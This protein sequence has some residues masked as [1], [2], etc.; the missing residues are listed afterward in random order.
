KKRYIENKDF[1]PLLKIDANSFLES[2]KIEVRESKEIWEDAPKG[3]H[4]F[5][6]AFEIVDN[7]LITG[8]LTEFGL[9][10]PTNIDEVVKEQYPWI[11]D[12]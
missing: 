5:N 8:Y 11:L 6:P 12:N 7:M 3:L 2:V 4:I 10:L 1:K 9:I